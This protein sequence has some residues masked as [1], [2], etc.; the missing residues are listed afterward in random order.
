MT[1]LSSSTDTSV[2]KHPFDRIGMKIL[3]GILGFI[4]LVAL[5]LWI[6]GG[7]DWFAGWLYIGLLTCGHSIS[8]L[9]LWRKNPEMLKSRAKI[10]KGTKT[11]DM[12]VLGIFGIAYLATVIVAA[13]DAGRYQTS[14][15]PFWLWP[16]GAI[17]YCF[18]LI[19]TTW[20]MAINPF[21]EKTVRIQHDRGHQVIDSGPYRIVRHPGYTATIIGFIFATPFLLGSWWAF[22]PAGIAG[23][24]LVLRTC[25]E[26]RTLRNELPGYDDYAQ[27][28]RYRLVPG[29]W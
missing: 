5:F 7:L 16:V 12:I 3:I 17:M 20:A 19:V 26:D 23:A 1:N 9:Y 27:R 10:G 25:L 14:G 2:K 15:M 22:V 11:W 24:S 13:L 4:L 18:F 29:I 8:A 21:F 6:A 28:V